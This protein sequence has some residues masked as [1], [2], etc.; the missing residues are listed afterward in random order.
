MNA[1]RGRFSVSGSLR[2]DLA[3]VLGFHLL[4][5]LLVA[6]APAHGGAR[7][8]PILLIAGLAIAL[9]GFCLRGLKRPLRREDRTA[10]LVATSGL[11]LIGGQ[12]YAVYLGASGAQPPIPSAI[13]LARIAS[14]PLLLAA[15]FAL[16]TRSLPRVV[17]TR[18]L[19]DWLMFLA[20]D[21]LFTWYFL[22][23]PSP[24]D[25][26]PSLTQTLV[27]DVYPFG[28]TLLLFS[29][30]LFTIQLRE[31]RL[32]GALALFGLCFV[33]LT[34]IDAIYRQQVLSG[35]SA[36]DGLVN[37]G[38][39]LG[40]MLGFLAARES[41][42]EPPL[43]REPAP[44]TENTHAWW[45][46]GWSAHPYVLVPLIGGLIL[47]ARFSAASA[48]LSDGLRFGFGVLLIIV[49]ARQLLVEIEN[50][51]LHRDLVAANERL[52]TQATTDP[53][54]GLPNQR[55]LI[56]AL[57]RE[58]ERSKRYGRAFAILFCDLDDFKL[59][60][61][62]HGHAT[63][64]TALRE[65]GSLVRRSIRATDL[66]GRWGGEEFLIVLPETS[67]ELAT[68]LAERLRTL[69]ASQSLVT[70][71]YWLTCSVGIAMYPADGVTRDA[72]ID[73][74]DMAMYAAK[75]LGRNQVRSASDP[76]V[77]QRREGDPGQP[78]GV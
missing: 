2:R 5:F 7:L 14:Y 66:I 28:D 42:R 33:V 72:L 38:W 18:I 15:V 61:D 70:S 19:L 53:L 26:V 8:A 34:A 71:T 47:Y 56:E 40:L 54:T 51:R 30:A 11:L 36:S 4:L 43:L 29:L 16:S 58:I 69:V 37:I 39:S 44:A 3:L 60:N 41:R 55:L 59:L 52:A 24:L 65:F 13:D 31:P 76:V 74:A 20:A 68:T 35:S 49:L 73:A 63:G 21:V 10:L 9:V 6:A 1:A 78:L 57:D 27:A 22:I 48:T 64:D 50:R 62:T 45:S 17:R 25:R 12:A 67:S 23:G 46:V 75:T 32:Y 77:S